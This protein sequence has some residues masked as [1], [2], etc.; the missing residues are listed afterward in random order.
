MAAA[1]PE[2]RTA[3]VTGAA[4]PRGIGRATAKLLASQGWQVAILDTDADSGNALAAEL[5]ERYAVGAAFHR[6]D[7]TDQRAVDEAVDRIEASM[8]QIVALANIA[9]ISSPTPLLE[10]TLDGWNRVI[11]VNLTGTFLVTRRVAVTMARNGV[12]RIVSISSVSFERG[13]GVFSK[14]AYAAAKG[15][16]VGLMRATA[17]ELGPAGVTANSISPG[18]VD[19]DIMGGTLTE[20]RKAEMS[21]GTVIGRVGTTADIAALAGFLLS[22]A[23]GNITGATIDSNGGMHML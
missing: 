2:Q 21:R 22:E 18:A 19:T 14:T 10:E 15:G 1:F 4:S 16:V 17:R 5:T 12:G 6:A 13:G 3:I 20:E 23:A 8:P 11:G 9:G 7:I